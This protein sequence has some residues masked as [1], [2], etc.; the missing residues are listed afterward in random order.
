MEREQ[1]PRE[2]VRYLLDLLS[3]GWRPTGTHL[4]WVVR[5]AVLLGLLLLIGRPYNITFWDWLDLLIVPVTVAVATTAGAAWF[6]RERARDTALQGYLDKM[7]ELLIDKQIHEEHGRY[8]DTRVTARAQTLAV[9]SQLDGKRKRT[10]LLFL[11][12]ARLINK[13]LYARE[14]RV[15]YPCIVGLRGAD[16]SGAHLR[17]AQLV[18]TDGKEAVS[19]EGADLRD[20]DMRGADLRGADLRGT[21]LRCAD[22]RCAIL[23][24]ADFGVSEDTQKAADLRGAHLEGADLEGAR[25]QVMKGVATTNARTEGRPYERV[26]SLVQSIGGTMAY[27]FGGG[28]SGVWELNLWGRT[29]RVEVHDNRIND[30]DRLY[31]AKVDSP[32]TWEDYDHGAP[33][34]EGAFW[35][36]VRLFQNQPE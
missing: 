36:L 21:D 1:T 19:L 3:F 7:S 9:L 10:V 30:L 29:A 33:L 27:R 15:I 31:I 18:S 11:R 16:L 25:C 28:H 4:L 2:Q 12:E 22:L 24:D 6:T 17:G 8:A 32:R 34:A 5:G 13:Q 20:A 14:S 23:S 35:G 26:R